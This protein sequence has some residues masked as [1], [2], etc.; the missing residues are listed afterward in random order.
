M[1]MSI[2]G[3]RGIYTIVRKEEIDITPAKSDLEPPFVSKIANFRA[4]SG[5][6]WEVQGPNYMGLGWICL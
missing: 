4:I 5:S 3:L 1:D 2:K 6:K